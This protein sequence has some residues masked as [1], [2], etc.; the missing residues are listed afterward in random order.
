[1]KKTLQLNGLDCAACAAEL[2][3]LIAKLDGIT[4][5]NIVFV[6]QKLTVEYETEEALQK[7]VEIAN[8]FEEVRVVET[9]NIS[10]SKPTHC[11]CHDGKCSCEHHE[12]G[13]AHTHKHKQKIKATKKK[14]AHYKEWIQIGISAIFFIIAVFLGMIKQGNWNIP[15]YVCYGI[16]YIIVGYP[17]ILSMIKNVTRGRIFDENF[18]MTIASF[19]A[20]YLGE[21][22]ESVLVML[23]YQFGELLQSIA[24]GASRTSIAQL[25]ELKSETATL[26]INGEQK[27]VKPEELNVGD[28]IL[29]KAGEKV[30]VDGVL[31]SEEALLDTKSLTGESEYRKSTNGNEIL[32]GCIN[33]GGTYEMKVS[34]V[35]ED[36]AVKKILDMVENASTRKA[37]PEKFITKFARYYTPIVCALAIAILLFAPLISGIVLDDK[38]YF[39]NFERWLQSA[40]T[41]LVV[42]C[43]CALII[44]VPLTYFSGIG[45]CAKQGI[46]VK[47]ATYLDVVAKANVV[48]FDKTGTLTEGNFTIGEVFTAQGL[49]KTE[50]LS[51]ATAVERGS[52]HPIA[53]AFKDVETKHTADK[54]IEIAGRG[55]EAEINGERVLVGNEKLLLEKG[56]EFPI[57]DSPYTL[58]YVA[59]AEKYLGVIEIG[60]QLRKEAKETV[61]ALKKLGVSRLVMLTGDGE[62]RAEKIANEAGI[63][64]VK[65]KLLPDEKLREAEKLKEQGSLLY[66]GDGINDTPVMVASDCAVSM[67][68]LGSAAAIEASDMVLI[69]DNLQALPTGI[70]IARK[71][72]KIVLQNIVFSILMKVAFMVLGVFGIL[73]LWLAVFADVGVMLLA[74]GNSFRVK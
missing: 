44:S 32:S 5:A 63:Y 4:S 25:M 30:P 59:R 23:L 14:F 20:I 8:H 61:S 53:L 49:A 46:L 36:S 52:S 18:L 6:T 11:H 33:V 64:E 72:R 26:L 47:G 40:L 17:V 12:Y 22:A 42:S 67:G 7:A 60:D 16:A 43:P 24:V 66:V 41:F 27:I 39:K 71:T 28:I 74:V 13:N 51:L 50:V 29:V 57:K 1:M 10:E 65:S 19:G 34:R 56:I 35:Y 70:R 58:V 62:V 68:T 9:S 31:L 38:L 37:K 15:Q 45:A 54:I 69:S 55:L 3:N 2:E 73:P 21:Y 48:A